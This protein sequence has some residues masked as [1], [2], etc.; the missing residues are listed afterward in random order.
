[1]VAGKYCGDQ[2]RRNVLL[3]GDRVSITFHSD[4]SVQSRGFEIHFTAV[5]HG[6]Y[7]IDWYLL[8]NFQC[9]KYDNEAFYHAR[10]VYSTCNCPPCCLTVGVY[11]FPVGGTTESFG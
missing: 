7:R 11:R 5:P 9:L 8:L 4:G 6:K 2:T 3:T 10:K 1:M